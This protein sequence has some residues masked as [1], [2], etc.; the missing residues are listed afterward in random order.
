V[1][2]LTRSAA[3]DFGPLNIRVNALLPGATDTPMLAP[4]MQGPHPRIEG[5]IQ[6]TPLRRVGL[7]SEQAEAVVWLCSDGA[8]YV[9]G[10]SLVVDGG[11]A[12]LR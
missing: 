3:V 9:S 5:L 8:A 12:V 10:L 11:L 6:R 1:I 7:A 4:A 2:G